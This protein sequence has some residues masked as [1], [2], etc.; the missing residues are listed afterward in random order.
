MPP[1]GIGHDAVL[2]N[3]IVD[4]NARIGD[5]AILVNSA[6]IVEGEGP[7]YVIREGIIVVP[8]GGVVPAGTRVGGDGTAGRRDGRRPAEPRS[9]RP[10][11]ANAAPED[12]RRQ[13]RLQQAGPGRR[14]QDGDV[15]P[16]DAA[17]LELGRRL[18]PDEQR[19]QLA[20][21]GLVPDQ[22]QAV[23]RPSGSSARSTSRGLT[24]GC[25]AGS[26]TTF[27]FFGERRRQQVGGLPRPRERAGQDQVGPRLDRRRA[28]RPAAATSSRRPSVSGRCESSGQAGPRS[29]ATAW[30]TR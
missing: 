12:L 15:D 8:K 30:R 10:A 17:L 9:V 26:S 13:P 28:R 22:R 27:G 16:G 14:R 29:S 6:G 2:E 21:A 1:L 3:V 23:V 5:G 18:E 7:G 20:E 11:A 4:K 25:S 19:R 24:P